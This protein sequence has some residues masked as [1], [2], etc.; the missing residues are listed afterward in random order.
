ML[1]LFVYIV[2]NEAHLALKSNSLCSQCFGVGFIIL[3]RLPKVRREKE[4]KKRKK[5]RVRERSNE[6]ESELYDKLN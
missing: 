2:E 5:K 4:E 1:K 3:Y 6:S